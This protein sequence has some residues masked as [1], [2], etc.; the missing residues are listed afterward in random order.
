MES[1]SICQSLVDTTREETH[2]NDMV[3]IEQV[4]V[5]NHSEKTIL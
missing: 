1:H 2:C 4:Q 3:N 5:S